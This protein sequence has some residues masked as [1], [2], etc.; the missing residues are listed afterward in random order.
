MIKNGCPNVRAIGVVRAVLVFYRK[1]R[2]RRN[3]RSKLHR[4]HPRDT[5]SSSCSR[6]WSRSLPRRLRSRDHPTEH[7]C[8][9]KDILY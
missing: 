9:S 6:R 2:T 7:D 1:I 3:R 4:R 5:R 8:K